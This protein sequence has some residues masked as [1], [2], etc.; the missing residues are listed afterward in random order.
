MK[1]PGQLGSMPES[2]PV[3]NLSVGE[4]PR[5]VQIPTATKISGRRERCG[6]WA[7]SGCCDATVESSN[8]STAEIASVTPARASRAKELLSC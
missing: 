6:L 8:A 2:A 4:Q 3:L 1:P 5:W 7:Y